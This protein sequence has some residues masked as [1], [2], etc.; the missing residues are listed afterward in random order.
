MSPRLVKVERRMPARRK[1]HLV[2]EVVGAFES[3]TAAVILRTAPGE[4]RLVLY[5]LVAIIVVSIALAAFVKLDRV[6]TG[7]GVIQPGG[8]VFYVS[9]YDTGI[10]KQILVK[11]GEVVR[12]GQ[13]L[14]TL[15]ATFTDADLEKLEQQ[16]SS[17][18]S[19]SERLRAEVA[20][21][22]YT[23][24]GP[25]G[26]YKSLQA[27]VNEQR[28]GE[29]QATLADY[30]GRIRAIEAQIVQAAADVREYEKRVALA[31][32][33]EKTYMPLLEKGYVSKLQLMQASDQRAE[34][35][36]L[37]ASS[38]NQIGTL[39]EN[40]AALKAQRRVF[41]SHWQSETGRELVSVNNDLDQTR[42]QLEKARKMRELVNL[43]APADGI[44][45]KIG[46]ISSGSVAANSA[47]NAGA[48]P[49]FTLVPLGAELEAALQIAPDRM[50]FVKPGD[51]VQI[52]LDA[53]RYIRHGTAQGVIKTLSEG[54]FDTDNNGQAVPTYVKAIVT[55][56][57][58]KLRDVPA[59][60]RLV[61]GMTLH[62]DVLVGSRT[63]LSY[64]VEG[65]LRTG[66]EAMREP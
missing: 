53:Y 51:S 12:K 17:N 50:G 32:E 11:P 16:L 44:V 34:M 62:G 20:G 6:V 42:Q 23:A 10:V 49:L 35:A 65:A 66:R 22:A 26:S 60:F 38:Q 3:E 8:G 59:D 29:Y 18:Q 47:P 61:P 45:L 5:A 9:P 15:D 36:R 40:M 1:A 48:E 43:T 7:V 41:V 63:I 64:L 37:L 55:L 33:V 46:K 14:A 2:G 56:R 19:A 13:V 39:R 4:E 58:V 24:K 30:D 27:G 28:R 25:A 31:D 52:K 21:R 54:T 57:E